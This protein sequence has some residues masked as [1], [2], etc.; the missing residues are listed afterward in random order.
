MGRSTRRGLCLVHPV[1]QADDQ[2]RRTYRGWK[3]SWRRRRAASPTQENL[4]LLAD[5]EAQEVGSGRP[6]FCLVIL[7]PWRLAEAVCC[8]RCAWLTLNRQWHSRTG[9][10]RYRV[11]PSDSS[12][13]LSPGTVVACRRSGRAIGDSTAYLLGVNE[14]QEGQYGS[15]KQVRALMLDDRGHLR[16][17]WL[18]PFAAAADKARLTFK[19]QRD[20]IA[21]RPRGS[22]CC[23]ICPLTNRAYFEIFGSPA[24]WPM[25]VDGR[26][27]LISRFCRNRNGTRAGSDGRRPATSSE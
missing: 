2:D 21:V 22:D 1:G 20:R 23:R 5:A 16:T 6:F 19:R 17:M 9:N 11:G 8:C 3:R 12:F 15:Y 24:G 25:V 4:E 14:W 18:L 13:W 10:V 7:R 27:S 26:L